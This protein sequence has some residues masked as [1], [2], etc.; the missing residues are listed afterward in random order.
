MRQRKERGEKAPVALPAQLQ[1]RGVCPLIVSLRLLW[2]Y[3][4]S[5]VFEMQRL[6]LRGIK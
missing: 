1:V 5:P 6:R 2:T 4:L 3:D